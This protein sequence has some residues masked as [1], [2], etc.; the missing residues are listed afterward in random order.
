VLA[1][2]SQSATTVPLLPFNAA[3]YDKNLPIEFF[4]EGIP[5]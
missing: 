3:G 5:A 2:H 4:K 1:A